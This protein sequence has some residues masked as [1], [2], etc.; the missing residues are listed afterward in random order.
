MKIFC[1]FAKNRSAR[2]RVVTFPRG[3]GC[4]GYSDGAIS[5]ALTGSVGAS[6]TL[7]T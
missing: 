1:K 2:E 6:K 5:G 3:I 4:R 7:I